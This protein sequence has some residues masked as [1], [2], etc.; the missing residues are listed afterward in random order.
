MSFLEP[1]IEATA[2][3]MMGGIALAMMA[4]YALGRGRSSV[5][6]ATLLRVLAVA[7]IVVPGMTIIGWYEQLR[8]TNQLTEA[9]PVHTAPIVDMVIV[10]SA[11]LL[12]AGFLL[13]IGGVYLARQLPDRPELAA[14]EP[15]DATE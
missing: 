15:A 5:W 1:L 4:V 14:G 12:S 7:G 3:A 9:L 2:P 11:I 6:P 10:N 13:L 8:R